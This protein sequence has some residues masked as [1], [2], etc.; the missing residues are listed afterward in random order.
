MNEEEGKSGTRVEEVEEGANDAARE[1]RVGVSHLKKSNSVEAE[2]VISLNRLR[3]NGVLQ[4]RGETTDDFALCLSFSVS[5]VF[6]LVWRWCL[7]KRLNLFFYGL[8]FN[9]IKL[10][11]FNDFFFYIIQYLLYK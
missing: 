8:Y 9:S 10:N 3:R 11:I 6:A 5:K 2:H 4:R 1:R 7:V